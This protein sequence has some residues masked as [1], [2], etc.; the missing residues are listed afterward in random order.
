MNKKILS[1]LIIACLSIT[2]LFAAV[3][4]TST[5]DTETDLTIYLNS[6][7]SVI[8]YTFMLVKGDSNATK[9]DLL[10]ISTDE[11]TSYTENTDIDILNPD[12][13]GTF[14]IISSIGNQEDDFSITIS[15]TPEAFIGTGSSPA[16]GP[17]PVVSNEEISD[18]LSFTAS[19]TGNPA[20]YLSEV[21]VTGKNQKKLLAGFSL[22]WLVGTPNI[23]PDSYT[24]T[25]TILIEST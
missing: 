14:G 2:G 5:T 18:S 15:I 23:R 22:E 10:A 11:G 1:L 13:V 25:T 24:S 9:V 17:T 21:F 20:Q 8:P 19:S 6:D 4:Y 12:S 16:T 3:G 7:V